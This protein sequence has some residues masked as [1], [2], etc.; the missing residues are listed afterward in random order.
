MGFI[1]L[2]YLFGDAASREFMAQLIGAGMGW[3]GIFFTAAGMLSV[4]LVVNFLLLK[5]TPAGL[6]LPEPPANP[7][8]LFGAA[9]ETPKPPSLR[10]LLAAFSRSPTFWLVCVL[11]LGVTIL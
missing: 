5:E 1:S 2:S 4:L 7:A 9:G 11:S 8:N 6:G 10:A 3:R